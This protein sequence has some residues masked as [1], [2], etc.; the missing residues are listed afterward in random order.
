MFRARG[1]N[2]GRSRSP[3]EKMKTSVWYRPRFAGFRGSLARAL[4]CLVLS[5]AFAAR[6]AAQCD[7]GQ[8]WVP[9][10]SNLPIHHPAVANP[11]IHHEAVVQVHPAVTHTE[12]DEFGNPYEVVDVPEW[13]EELVPA[14]DEPVPDTPAYDEPVP[15][16]PGY[17]REAAWESFEEISDWQPA[18]EWLPDASTIPEGEAYLRSRAIAK[19]RR[20]GE[21]SELGEERNVT[22]SV[23]DS[24]IESEPAVGTMEVWTEFT[25]ISDTPLTEWTPD[26]NT[27]PGGQ[28][29]NQSRMVTRT[30]RS[31][32]KNGAGVERNVTYET[33][34]MEV[35]QPSIG[36]GPAEVWTDFSEVVSS[37]PTS[38][39]AP[40]T[41]T[42][43]V[44]QV[45]TQTRTLSVT[46][47]TGQRNA[48]G[49]ERN[50]VV[51]SPSQETETNPNAVG[52]GPAT[53][54]PP[55]GGGG[56]GGTPSGYSLTVIG[57]S[58]SGTGLASG[59]VRNIS[60]SVPDGHHFAGW[61]ILGSGTL[62]THR[63]ARNG[64][65]AMGNGDV[66]V[67]ADYVDITPG[68]PFWMD[69]DGDGFPDE[70]FPRGV[71]G[72][73][74]VFDNFS[75]VVDPE[76]TLTFNWSPFNVWL[77]G[78]V[79]WSFAPNGTRES[80]NPDH[81]VGGWNL[82]PDFG[83]TITV[84]CDVSG[85]FAAVPGERYSILPAESDISWRGLL[86]AVITGVIGGFFDT[87]QFA[88]SIGRY[89]L[90]RHGKPTPTKNATPTLFTYPSSAFV[91]SYTR[92]ELETKIGE[93]KGRPLTIEERKQLDWGCIG[94]AIMELRR[95]WHLPSG[96]DVETFIR[97]PLPES[98]V[99]NLPKIFG[100]AKA[101]RTLAQAQAGPAPAN[102]HRVIFVKFGRWKNDTPPVD[103]PGGEP[104]Q[105]PVDSVVELEPARKGT[106]NYVTLINGKWVYMNVGVAE[107]TQTGTI[108]DTPPITIGES[109]WPGFMWV[110]RDVPN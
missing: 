24:S 64:R 43:P 27:V 8:I 13:T 32:Q 70:V 93:L 67:E 57:G 39:W 102:T 1:L 15:D 25:T 41:S 30:H 73:S 54:P 96:T 71:G 107:G 80:I 6:G 95:V 91:F 48:A 76:I 66:I 74:Y 110:R 108:S 69:V 92:P 103:I 7:P 44:N 33:G 109:I 46:R 63:L 34:D 85:A 56:G 49:V 23:A 55:T 106:F 52:T 79:G 14:Y 58:G 98:N 89:F 20:V 88:D 29:F 21:R 26:Q 65:V 9:P 31:G 81:W 4:L 53:P 11:P 97:G 51:S 17:C 105:I 3:P 86:P 35:V 42:Q 101:F 104:G 40:A 68:Q 72:F 19:E 22:T 60:A 77:N 78:L 94:I 82:R 5:L 2:R 47:R 87:D 59:A 12:F 45:F 90:V 100:E 75:A 37:S 83:T 61:T 28:S 36:T 62:E 50:V 16:T 84:L 99:A 10:Q 38:E 18:G